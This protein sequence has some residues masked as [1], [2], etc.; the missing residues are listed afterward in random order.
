MPN[1]SVPPPRCLR[2]VGRRG[3]RPVR[4][5][6]EQQ[7][8]LKG[9]GERLRARCRRCGAYSTLRE[10]HESLALAGDDNYKYDKAEYRVRRKG[11]PWMTPE[12]LEE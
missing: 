7:W 1:P 5:M 11:R 9:P 12:R 3:A 6:G 10:D 2:V 8:R 4:C